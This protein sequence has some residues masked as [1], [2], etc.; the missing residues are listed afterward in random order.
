MAV[1]YFGPQPGQFLLL[2]GLAF[3][4]QNRLVATDGGPVP[5]IEVFRYI[6]DAEVQAAKSGSAEAATKTKGETK[7]ERK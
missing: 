5:R 4:K 3:D 2:T 6:T 1:G 7:Q